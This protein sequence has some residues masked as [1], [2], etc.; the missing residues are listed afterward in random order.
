MSNG[1]SYWM[2]GG[3]LQ[4]HAQFYRGLGSVVDVAG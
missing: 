2:E 4:L 1:S 3:S